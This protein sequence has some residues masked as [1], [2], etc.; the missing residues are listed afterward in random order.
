MQKPIVA[1]MYDFDKTL[2]TKDM[3]EFSFIPEY[4]GIEAQDFWA[5]VNRFTKQADM[6]PILAY[7]RIMIEQSEALD[8]PIKRQELV[9]MGKDIEFFPGVL[10]W[11]ERLDAYGD[12][13][14][15]QLEHYVISSG[16]KEIIEGTV[17]KKAFKKIYACEFLYNAQGNAYWPK[18]AVNYTA[19][20]QFLFRINKGT[21]GISDDKDV[22][23]YIREEERRVPF[24]NM[25]YIGDGLTDIPCMRLVKSYGGSSIVVYSKESY[26]TA[27]QLYNDRRVN[28]I[29]PADYGE[30]SEMEK[31]CQ[32]ILE[33]VQARANLDSF[34]T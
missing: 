27:L 30:G 31:I 33:L 7:M 29:T 21:L 14:G 3:Q 17:I 13:L 10:D 5:E 4:L 6:D 1:M 12:K 9:E 28:F 16:L 26:A 15:I 24:E 32:N 22:N 20:T 19:K 2:C 11:F 25:I 23:V 34:K 18:L 8:K